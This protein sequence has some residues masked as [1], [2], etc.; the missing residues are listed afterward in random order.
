M[1]RICLIWIHDDRNSTRTVCKFELWIFYTRFLLNI[2]ISWN[3]LFFVCFA[4][5]I[6][7]LVYSYV[8][9]I[10]CIRETWKIVVIAI[11]AFWYDL[12]NHCD[13]D[14]RIEYSIIHFDF[15]QSALKIWKSSSW[16]TQKKHD[17]ITQL[18]VVFRIESLT[19]YNLQFSIWWLT[20]NCVTMRFE[21]ESIYIFISFIF[22]IHISKSMNW[23]KK[24]ND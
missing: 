7:R 10:C 8:V 18:F 12:K 2:E 14:F 3:D 9:F 11:F 1:F 16:V 20:T 6:Y 24:K 15:Y 23:R 19:S 17:L 22:L 5:E 13:R 4:T 21:F